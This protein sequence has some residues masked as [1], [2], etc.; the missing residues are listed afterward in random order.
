M[1]VNRPCENDSQTLLLQNIPHLLCH[2][3][4]VVAVHAG[5]MGLGAFGIAEMGAGTA[6]E[7]ADFEIVEFCFPGVHTQFRGGIAPDDES[8]FLQSGSDM[9]QAS[10]MRYH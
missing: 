8:N 2:F 6:I 9:H 7:V 1:G 10:V 3:I 5:E 4:R